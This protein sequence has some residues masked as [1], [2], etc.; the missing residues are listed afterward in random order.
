MKVLVYVKIDNTTGIRYN[1][2]QKIKKPKGEGEAI[3]KLN[4]LD[5]ITQKREQQYKLCVLSK[6]T[7]YNF[8]E[9]EVKGV[10]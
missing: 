10:D 6:N 4:L 7:K 8:Y 2:F 1:E 3:I 9:I 5:P